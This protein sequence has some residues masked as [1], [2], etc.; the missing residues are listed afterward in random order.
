MIQYFI[1]CTRK[2][3]GK[4]HKSRLS[5]VTHPLR[6]FPCLLPQP[7]FSCF[8]AAPGLHQQA[9]PW[10]LLKIFQTRHWSESQMSRSKNLGQGH[11][12][13]S[14]R[15]LKHSAQDT[16]QWWSC[17]NWGHELCPPAVFVP[18]RL[19]APGGSLSPATLLKTFTSTTLKTVPPL[20]CCFQVWASP[21]HLL[22]PLLF[23]KWLMKWDKKEV[24]E[25]CLTVLKENRPG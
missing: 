9:P 11:W 25:D 19:P 17:E 10:L 23:K 5:A 16:L 20:N 7:P 15:S 21:K 22:F 14:D 4:H 6:F 8:L 13:L 24:N 18:G 12:W 2:V 1:L 3:I